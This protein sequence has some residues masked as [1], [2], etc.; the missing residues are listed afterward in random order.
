MLTYVIVFVFV[1][2]FV[3]SKV[4]RGN[5]QA[6]AQF[7]TQTQG[8]L[9]SLYWVLC[10]TQLNAFCHLFCICI[11]N[12]HYL[13]FAEIFVFVFAVVF[14]VAFVLHASCELWAV[15]VGELYLGHF[16]LLVLRPAPTSS[17]DS[18]RVR[19]RHHHHHHHRWCLIII[20]TN[21]T[22]TKPVCAAF[23]F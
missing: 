6:G 3:F 23:S 8:K 10:T 9:T 20:I 17:R 15:P 2:I 4:L 19:H 22:I 13:S 1:F 12:T 16:L 21:T 14:A 7:I 18:E 11:F 5:W